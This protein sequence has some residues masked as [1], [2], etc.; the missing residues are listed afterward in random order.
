MLVVSRHETSSWMTDECCCDCVICAFVS[1]SSIISYEEALAL[2]DYGSK[3]SNTL[4]IYSTGFLKQK[5]D[6]SYK[7]FLNLLLQKH[8]THISRI[9]NWQE[10]ITVTD[11]SQ[12]EIETKSETCLVLTS[13][14][15]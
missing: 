4:Q 6:S 7:T 10:I 8:L 1:S 5:M 3:Y 15:A 13:F 2:V 9:Q 14:K 12:N 11:T